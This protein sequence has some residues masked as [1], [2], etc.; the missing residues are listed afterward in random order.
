MVK[1]LSSQKILWFL[2]AL[3]SLIASLAG[4]ANQTI[5]PHLINIENLSGALS[6]DLI[7]IL[8]V[9]VMLFL[10][11][12]IKETD[13]IKQMIVLGIIGY[14]FYCYG[15]YV[16]ERI[17]NILYFLYMAIFSL[18][19]YS[20]IYAMMNIRKE[21]YLKVKVPKTIRNLAMVFLFLLPLIFYPLWISKIVTLIQT[22]QKIELGYAIFILDICLILPLCIITGIMI[23]KKEGWALLLTPVL[24]VKTITLCSSVIL[25][26][27][28]KP[29]Y[30]QAANLVVIGLTV[31]LTLAGI[32]LTII[33]FKNMRI[34]GDFL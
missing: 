1:K 4:V 11:L 17:F 7:A 21:Y 28:L 3:L 9:M 18:S 25:G 2:I 5:Y 30:N 22:A 32:V 20:L 13:V 23:I 34:S 24:F 19:F 33:Y 8:A 10:I 12:K 26:E 15:I 16:M 27:I 14:L 31:F 29:W 6:Q